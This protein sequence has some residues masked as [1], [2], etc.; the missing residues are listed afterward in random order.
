[1]STTRI[2]HVGSALCLAAFL[3]V[4]LAAEVVAPWHGADASESQ[5]LSRVG[6]Q[7]GAANTADLLFFLGILLAVAAVVA[8]GRVLWWD[9][10]TAGERRPDLT[11]ASATI[12]AG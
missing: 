9:D 1:M 7:R 5:A 12:P 10:D 8:A 4:L 11:T 6:D 3:V 2:R